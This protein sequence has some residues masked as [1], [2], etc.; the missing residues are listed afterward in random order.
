MIPEITCD[1][2]SLLMK[3]PVAGQTRCTAAP[4]VQV[5]RSGGLSSSEERPTRRHEVA[6]GCF[7]TVSGAF[8]SVIET[9]SPELIR[10]PVP[11]MSEQED[12]P[13]AMIRKHPRN[14]ISVQ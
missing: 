1:S 8:I 2:N 10:S 11:T 12:V 7:D 14:Q 13:L 6:S 5:R 4:I 3:E 9:V